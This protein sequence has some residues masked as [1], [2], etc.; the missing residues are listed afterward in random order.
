VGLF[1]R[2]EKDHQNMSENSALK[3]KLGIDVFKPGKV[4]HIKIKP[5]REKDARLQAAILLCPAGL[6]RANEKGEVTLTTD[7]CLECGTCLVACGIE[8]LD[9]NYPE[10][11]TGVQY[12]YG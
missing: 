2:L 12:R 7:G 5:G 1:K 3:A 6:Y 4:A 8:V 11:G 9:W 10:G